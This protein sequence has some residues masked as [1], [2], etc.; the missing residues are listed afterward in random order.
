MKNLPKDSRSQEIGRLAAR[1]LGIKLPKSW[2]ETPLAGDTD[3]GIDYTIQLKSKENFV[4]YSFYLQLKGT[5]VPSY[6]VDKNYISHDFDVATLNNYYQQEPLVMV[7]VVDLSENEDNLSD[8]PIYYFWLED[9]WFSANEEKLEKQKSISIKIPTQNILNPSLNVF[10]Y[11]ANRIAEKIAVAELKKKIQIPNKTIVESIELFTEAIIDKPIL[12]KLIELKS[13]APWID[14]PK[15]EVTTD[16]KY[17]SDLLENNRVLEAKKIL[18]NL[19]EKKCSFTNH[20]LAE[21]YY[22]K[23][24]ISSYEGFFDN[25]ENLYKLSYEKSHKERYQLAYLQS[26]FKLDSMPSKAEL[27][28]IVNTLDDGN[29]VKCLIKAKS[30]ALLKKPLEALNFLKQKYPNEI[31]AQ[32]GI[33]TIGELYQELDEIIDKNINLN[34]VSERKSYDFYSLAARRYFHKSS[35]QTG[36]FGKTLPLDGLAN[37]DIEGMK[38]SYELLERAWDSAKKI[39]YPSDVVMLMDISPLIYGYFNKLDEL[40]RLLD[41]IL[42]E[43]PYNKEII[44]PYIRILFNSQN[45]KKTI[46]LIERLEGLD[47]LDADECGI[48]I[49]SYSYL[50]Q[51]KQ[52]LDSINKYESILIN[53]GKDNIPV[54]FCNGIEIAEAMF[55][56]DLVEKYENIVKKLPEGEAFLAIQKFVT[57]SN[58]DRN[59]RNE[60]AQDLYKTYLELGKPLVI[61]EQLLPYLDPHEFGTAQQIIELAEQILNVRELRKK[62]YLDLAQAFLTT[63][64]WKDAEKL[65]EKNINKGIAISKWKLVQALALKKQ[66][67]VGMAYNIMREAI[68]EDDTDQLNQK[69]YINLCFSLGFIEEAID[70][71]ENNLVKIQDINEKIYIIRSLIEI[72]VKNPNYISK[73]K[74]AIL[75]YGDLVDQNNVQQEGDY[76]QLCMLYTPFENDKQIEYYQERSNRYFENFPDSTILRRGNVDVESGVENFLASLKKLTGVTPEL[77]EQ[78]ESNKQKLR[79]RE[80]PVP[81]FM[82]GNFL[83]NTRDVYT[84]WMLS[85]CCKEEET[86]YKITH[87][88]QIETKVFFRLVESSNII[89]IEETSLLILN[90]LNILDFFLK[91][92][93][94]FSILDSVFKRINLTTHNYISPNSQI[95]GAILRAIQNNIEKLSLIDDSGDNFFKYDCISESED[96]LLLT[97]DL[98]LNI[99]MKQHNSNI[100]S[101]NV[102]NV[103]DYLFCKNII[104]EKKFFEKIV[105]CFSLGILSF[106]IQF[107]FL[108][109]LINYYLGRGNIES[110]EDT[111]FKYVFDRLLAQAN[112]FKDKLNIFINMFNSVNIANLSPEILLSLISKLLEYNPTLDPQD[113]LNTWLIYCGIQREIRIDADNLLSNVHQELWFKYKQVVEF[114]NEIPYKN[115]FLLEEVVKNI[116]NKVKSLAFANLKASFVKG[117]GEYQY[118]ESVSED[119]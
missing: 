30:L 8:C 59:R 1:A 94:K 69:I 10:N 117:S 88:P 47:I 58:N 50:E 6:S 95:S 35:N 66:G 105:D 7:A 112:S 26:K 79:S 98:Y 21:F 5:T 103:L 73:L 107:D 25:A 56:K 51:Y 104:S 27:E 106:N 49:L 54:I 18:D 71:L 72:Y 118:L 4:N 42:I 22:Q 83:Q 101:A 41:I 48:K 75:K 85:K 44:R 65:A 17:C 68:K 91:N 89:L 45:Y 111:N 14:N 78:W 115:E 113:V 90:E 77:E 99:L 109:K 81:F 28:E 15:G 102:F 108:S 70:I 100:L 37:Y 61:A 86:E 23:A 93:P 16:L 19:E 29:F 46:N 38:L 33:C 67:K 114:L 9:E 84:T 92:L 40:I 87:S 62:R 12:L 53:S 76:L 11:Y 60:F 34:F 116:N 2:I 64:R 57:A 74:I 36:I 82:R 24:N 3:F 31:T 63:G 52:C 32:M 55:N 97:D 43:R 110:Y 39:G 20:E 13:E 80:L 96:G 119:F